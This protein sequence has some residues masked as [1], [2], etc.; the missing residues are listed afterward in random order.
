MA[1]NHVMC[2]VFDD[3]SGIHLMTENP[4]PCT[5]PMLTAQYILDFKRLI[6]AILDMQLAITYTILLPLI[7][8][9][10]AGR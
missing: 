9:A 8:A 10:C 4:R 7:D 2:L 5:Y 1:F 3:A 6:A